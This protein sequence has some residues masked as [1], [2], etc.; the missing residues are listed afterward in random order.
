[1]NL[2]S[3]EEIIQT[4]KTIYKKINSGK[5]SDYWDNFKP[6]PIAFYDDSYVY[7]IGFDNPPEN[8]I[9]EQG[10]FIGKWNERFVG[11][12]AINY[13]GKYMGIWNISTVDK[14]ETF[15][16]FYSKIVHEIFHGFQF[17]NKD[18]RFANEFLAFQ[19]PFTLENIALRILER[20][21][22]LK[23][24][25][26][27][28][29]Q[30]KTEYVKKFISFREKRRH[31]INSF[32]DYE[33]GLESMEGTATYVEYR[34][35]LDESKFPQSFLI[36]L[37]GENLIKIRDLKN[38]RASCYSTG[39]YISLL[40]DQITS[41]WKINYTTSKKYLYDFFLDIVK[42][43]PS[44]LKDLLAD[45]QTKKLAQILIQKRQNDINK[46]FET[47]KKTNGYK[48][49]LEGE[50]NLS[51]FDP[52]NILKKDN[53]LLHK[54]FLKIKFKEKE[55]FIKGPVV[56]EMDNKLWKYKK[57]IFFSSQKPKIR[58]KNMIEIDD[59]IKIQGTLYENK[60]GFFIKNSV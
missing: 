13:N 37:F 39:M 35:L 36:S 46:A 47:F 50:F 44:D 54:T 33:L 23:S 9:E 52:M 51:G 12:A 6:L 7:I 60:E 19:Y 1:M 56:S 38:F 34:A 59:I 21:Y 32:L 14:L 4:L 15:P 26:E 57:I 42:Y 49:V 10:I 5:L 25:F 24:V 43:Q 17:L 30:L 55:L 11:N 29:K 22:L 16:F 41:N 8:F 3:K 40:L 28:N 45:E 27:T 18:K 20:K 48:I 53:L 31:L 2:N 58:E